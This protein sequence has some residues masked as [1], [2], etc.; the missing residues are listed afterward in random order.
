MRICREIARAAGAEALRRR[1]DPARRRRSPTTPSCSADIRANGVSNLHP[2]G[3]CRMGREADAVVD[4][5]LRVHGIERL[6]VAD[7]SIMPSHRRRQHQRALDH[8]RR[9]VRRHGAPGGAVALRLL[10]RG[11][12]G[13][14]HSSA[15]ANARK[16]T[17]RPRSD[18]NPSVVYHAR[19]AQ[20][21]TR[22]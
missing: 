14:H 6:R 17:W 18:K 13:P 1:G 20:R 2:V 21:G 10:E 15:H 3:T 4:P 5:Q 22:R 9:E 11:P 7:A 19:R 16:R 8:D 12:P